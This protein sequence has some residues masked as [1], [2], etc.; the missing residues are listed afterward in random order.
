MN[1]IIIAAISLI[2]M[3]VLIAIFTGRITLFQEKA[4][5]GED[6]AKANICVEQGG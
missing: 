4:K 2:V 1:V 3:I 5:T 6:L